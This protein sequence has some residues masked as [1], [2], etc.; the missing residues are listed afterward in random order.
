MLMKRTVAIMALAMTLQVSA[1]TPHQGLTDISDSMPATAVVAPVLYAYT[2]LSSPEV[3]TPI[4]W[5]VLVPERE[6][7]LGEHNAKPWILRNLAPSGRRGNGWG[8][9]GTHPQH[10]ATAIVARRWAL[11][12]VAASGGAGFMVGPGGVAG[13]VAGGAIAQ[14]LPKPKLPITLGGA[15]GGALAGKLLW[16]KMFPPDVPSL[17]SGPEDDIA[18]EVFVRQKMCSTTQTVSHDQSAYRVGYRF[19]GQERVADLP[20]DPGEALLLNAA[21]NITGPARVRLD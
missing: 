5:Q 2:T 19:N 3:D 14:A 7:L 6:V 13:F 17:P 9:G 12:V 21:G 11:P 4:C 18:V 16:E 20:Y 15:V 1:Q 8:A 10:H